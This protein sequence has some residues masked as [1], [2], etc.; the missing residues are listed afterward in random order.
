MPDCVQIELC[1]DRRVSDESFQF[2]RPDEFVVENAVVKWLFA[3]AVASKDQPPPPK[4]P[5]RER[6]HSIDMVDERIAV[7]CIKMR[8]YLG[9]RS[10]YEHNAFFFEFRTQLVIV[11]QLAVHHHDEGAVFPTAWL[12]A[13]LN[14]DQQ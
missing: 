6:V 13:R 11:V 3:E 1:V 7:F 9:V 5:E 4:I 8:Q 12:V 2:R 14:I 10:R